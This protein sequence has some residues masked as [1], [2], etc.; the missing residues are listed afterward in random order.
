MSQ[1]E[2]SGIDIRTIFA[3][4]PDFLV[5]RQTEILESCEAH[6]RVKLIGTAHQ[7]IISRISALETLQRDT[8]ALQTVSA[9]DLSTLAR[10]QTVF[11]GCHASIGSARSDVQRELLALQA[12]RSDRLGG[13]FPNNSW[14]S[15]LATKT[16]MRRCG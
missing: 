9:A 14:S 15:R 11:E 1:V 8:S 12:V 10:R 6:H 16:V 3:L 5:H 2:P 13:E 4:L 7:T